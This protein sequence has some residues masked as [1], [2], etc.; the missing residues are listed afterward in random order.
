MKQYKRFDQLNQMFQLFLLHIKGHLKAVRA[1]AGEMIQY[2]RRKKQVCAQRNI[3][4]CVEEIFNHLLPFS[5][6]Q[7]LFYVIILFIDWLFTSNGAC[8]HFSKCLFQY[9]NNFTRNE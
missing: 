1:Q 4:Y 2:L 5:F 3:K 7:L 8:F 6:E 9:L